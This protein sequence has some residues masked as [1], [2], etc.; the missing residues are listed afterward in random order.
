MAPVPGG[1]ESFVADHASELLRAAVLLTGSRHDGEDLLQ[2]TL[3][4]VYPCWEMVAPA[5]APV[6]YVRR[7]VVN[8]FVSERR[9]P[10]SATL[11]VWDVP[12]RADGPRSPSPAA[13]LLL[14]N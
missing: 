5:A 7:A 9:A 2:A 6:A 8:R 4:H 12:D 1:F 14:P 11:P 10:R 3:T 13:R